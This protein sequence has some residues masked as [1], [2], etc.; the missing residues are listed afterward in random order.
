M[1]RAEDNPKLRRRASSVSEI[2]PE[3]TRRA[4]MAVFSEVDKDGSGFVDREELTRVLS[5]LEV[6]MPNPADDV[7]ALFEAIDLDCSGSIDVFEFC[8]KFEPNFAAAIQRSGATDIAR[9]NIDCIFKATFE[10]ML[11]NARAARA[12][13]NRLKDP[14]F[15]DRPPPKGGS[16]NLFTE[17]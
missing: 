15:C 2:T 17:I 16:V 14:P 6:D 1:G 8:S 13:V 11:S 3:L 9:L 4:L 7:D 12:A 5:I 10:A